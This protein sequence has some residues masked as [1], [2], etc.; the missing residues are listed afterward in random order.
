MKK[1]CVLIL[2]CFF[3]FNNLLAQYSTL[4]NNY[5]LKYPNEQIT[6]INNENIIEISLQKNNILISEQYNS[7][8]IFLNS[9]AKYQA[10]ESIYYT[11]FFSIEEI[12]A[13]SFNYIDGEYKEFKVTNFNEKDEL[14][15]SSFYYNKKSVNF[16][17]SGLQPGSRAKISYL[18]NIKNPRF[19]GSYLLGNF[20]PIEK[21]KLKIIANKNIVLDFK[22]L[23][24][25]T[26]N[27]LFDK[28]EKGNNNIYEWTVSNINGY[29]HDENSINYKYYIPQIIPMI[30]Y[31]YMNKDTT[32]ILNSTQDLYNWYTSLIK[33]I[34]KTPCN[35]NLIRLV[36]SLTINCKTNLEKVKKIYYWTQQNIKYVA[37][38]D[39]LGGFVPRDAN[40]VFQKKY[41]DCKDNASILEQMLKHAGIK[42]HLTWVGTRDIPYKYNEIYS[43][44][45]DNHMILTYFDNDST[46]YFLDATGRYLNIEIPSSFIQGKE[47]LV[48]IDYDTYKIVPIPIVENNKNYI[49]DSMEIIIDNKIIRGKGNRTYNGYEKINI[50]NILERLKTKNDISN[51][52]KNTLEK[53]NNN[54]LLD[55]LYETN[56]YDYEKSFNVN[57]FFNINNYL[58]EIENKIYINLNLNKGDVDIIKNNP[59]YKT[60]IEYPHLL[61]AAY[62]TVFK[63]PDNYEVEFLPKNLE[64]GNEQCSVKINYEVQNNEISY[65]H[66]IETNFLILTIEQQKSLHELLEK[67]QK[68][69]KEVVVLNLKKL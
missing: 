6:Q 34:N 29:P 54:F 30:K 3:L 68:N 65:F 37:F 13:S 19:L 41:G 23:Y 38:E 49:V 20:F 2:F 47:A 63:L 52:Y 14:S 12:S 40:E 57:Y 39:G 60:T 50:F 10:K 21:F 66:T 22:M 69:Y 8:K 67:V 36:D 64:I 61:K 17:Y 53:G 46:P 43:P 31:Y 4:Y 24:C 56:K 59:P 44:I 51:Y 28:K 7:E 18:T 15:S 42:G 58:K 32:Y 27:I 5:K 55:S 35:N 26:L 33:D 16:Y 45:V 9:T 25:D 11:D 48:S 62:Y 1:N